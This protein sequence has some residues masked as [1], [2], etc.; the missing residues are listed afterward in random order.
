MLNYKELIVWQSSMSLA[1]EVYKIIKSFPHYEQYGL[2]DQMRRAAVSIPSNI[3]EWM[4]RTGRSQLLF[5]K[6]ASWS[7]CELETQMLIAKRLG[8][9]DTIDN[10]LW[11]L[12]QILKMLTALKKKVRL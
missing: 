5:L 8:Y 11:D 4:Q 6:I 3:A 9:I 2:S 12:E 7:A 10:I 1:E